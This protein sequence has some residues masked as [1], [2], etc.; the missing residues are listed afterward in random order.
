MSRIGTVLRNKNRVEKSQR[1]RRR[2]EISRLRT[3]NLYRA[4]LLDYIRKF[5][6]LLELG[7]IQGVVIEV[8]D[9]NLPLFTES[10]YSPE[11]SL[12]AIE[13]DP[14]NA[15]QFIISLREI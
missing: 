13:Q 14:E 6:I 2:A 7:G 4:C 15:N 5:E 10:M 8:S 9:K 3:L 12:Y 11:M 1:A